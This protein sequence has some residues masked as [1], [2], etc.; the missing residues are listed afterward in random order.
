MNA[1]MTNTTPG[2]CSTCTDR[3]NPDPAANARADAR[4]AAEG[5]EMLGIDGDEADRVISKYNAGRSTSRRGRHIESIKIV[6]RQL[7][8]ADDLDGLE[9]VVESTGW[10]SNLTETTCERLARG[11]EALLST[12][13]DGEI[14]DVSSVAKFHGDRLRKRT[15]K[16]SRKRGGTEIAGSTGAR[17]DDL[18]FL[19]DACGRDLERMAMARQQGAAPLGT[20]SAGTQVKECSADDRRAPGKGTR[21]ANRRIGTP[22]WCNGFPAGPARPGSAGETPFSRVALKLVSEDVA[23][24]SFVRFYVAHGI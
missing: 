2:R 8:E 23:C 15:R 24:V 6:L 16:R 3:H 20:A 21:V 9:M 1:L 10:L 14:L 11:I 4:K 17:R 12:L 7:V 22:M 19:H 13:D 18:T 5:A